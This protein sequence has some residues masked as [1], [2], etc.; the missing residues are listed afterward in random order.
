MPH[1]EQRDL[2][3]GAP[4]RTASM[5]VTRVPDGYIVDVTACAYRWTA[6]DWVDTDQ[7]APVL[8]HLRDEFL[9]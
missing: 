4:D 5:H 6:R 2:I 7:H 1:P 3:S 9:Q 8:R